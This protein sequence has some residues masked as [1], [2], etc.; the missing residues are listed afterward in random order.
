MV[1]GYKIYS[2]ILRKRLDTEMKDRKI[3]SETQTG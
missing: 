1:T 3:M 2:E